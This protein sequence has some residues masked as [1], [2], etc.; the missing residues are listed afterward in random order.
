MSIHRRKFLKQTGGLALGSV[1][2]S[3]CTVKKISSMADPS[4]STGTSHFGIQL[5]TLRD[6]LPKDPAGVLKQVASFG[7]KQIESY[8][9]SNGM[10][11]GMGHTGFKKYMDDLGMKIVSSHCDINT[12]FEKKAAEAAEIGMKYLICP[13]LGPQ[14]SLDDFKKAAEKFN[15]CG[16]I[17]KKE[18]IL[19]AY[20]NHDYSFKMQEGQLPQDLMMNETDPALVDFE[21]DIYWVVA[22][23]KDPEE[24]FRNHRN[25]FRLCHVKDRSKTPGPDNGKNSVDLGTGSIDW[26]KVL[27]TAAEN[28]MQYFIVEQEAYPNGSPL[29]AA[30]TDALYMKKLKF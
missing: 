27:H 2:L 22:A 20:H 24:W 12:G 15:R 11:W 26:K 8:E 10:F 13:W 25:R 9:G 21:M 23:G 3:S 1:V 17:C 19:F 29:E 7:Y 18:G 30:K 16:E 14:K 28:G 6:D 4:G 5:Y